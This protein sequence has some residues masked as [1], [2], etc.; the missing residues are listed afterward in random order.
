MV[1]CARRE[2]REE[3]GMIADP[4]RVAFVLEAM[5][6]DGQRRT[7]DLV[8]I[9]PTPPPASSRN[10]MNPAWNQ[11]SC[12]WPKCLPWTCVPPSGGT[13]AVYARTA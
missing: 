10:N 7:V 5:W 6:P 4:T 13:C 11:C 2:M 8:F 9:A 3:T 12:P 1:A